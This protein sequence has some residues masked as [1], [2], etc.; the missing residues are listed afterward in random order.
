[1]EIQ[2]TTDKNKNDNGNRNIINVTARKLNNFKKH[3]QQSL[4]SDQDQVRYYKPPKKV[5]PIIWGSMIK[6]M[7]SHHPVQSKLETILLQQLK[8]FL[9]SKNNCLKK[10]NMMVINTDTDD[11]TN[12][13]ST[14]Q[15]IR[16]VINKLKTI[17]CKKKLK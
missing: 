15:K 8:T 12:K 1:M 9:V 7:N 17:M 2:K 14:I 13:L 5:T 4:E 6:Y 3:G 10:L 11:I 16:K